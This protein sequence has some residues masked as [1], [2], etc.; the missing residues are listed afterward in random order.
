[1]AAA[2]L[3][4]LARVK[5]YL[6]L[7]STNS[8]WN[9]ILNSLITQ[10]SKA[11]DKYCQRV[12]ISTGSVTE[13]Y[14]GKRQREL[15]LRKHPV[16]S[17]TSVHDDYA[18]VFPASTLVNSADYYVDTDRGIIK[19]D[20]TLSEGR[21]NIKVVYSAGYTDIASL[22]PNVVLAANKLVAAVFNK[23]KDDGQ[24]GASLGNVSY[25]YEPVITADV[26]AL[27]EQEMN[28]VESS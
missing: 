9:D 26:A 8:T 20:V 16:V 28:L 10:C 11:I 23:R 27:L 17:V 24:Q 1:M 5:E 3:T 4:T 21:G 25:S 19:F 7:S 2:D 13:F 22:P 6:Q 12:F 15:V 18:R 14:D